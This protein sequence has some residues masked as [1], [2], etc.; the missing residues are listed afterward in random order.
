MKFRRNVHE[1]KF[2]AAVAIIGLIVSVI[3]LI[4]YF[5]TSDKDLIELFVWSLLIP[6]LYFYSSF[7]FKNDFIDFQEDRIVI[8]NG[9][10]GNIEISISN[11]E[12]I[13]IPSPTALK[14]KFKGNNI[15]FKRQ[16]FENIKNIVTYTKDIENYIKE[17]LD[18]S[19]VYYDNYSDALKS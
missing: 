17:H 19:I 3:L 14:N 10:G 9:L 7:K 15:I 11:I 6:P 1:K 5:I 4:V 13:L 16:G 12:A 8:I 2:F 18:V